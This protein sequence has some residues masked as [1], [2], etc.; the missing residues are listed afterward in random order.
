MDNRK[1]IEEDKLNALI[2]TWDC[3]TFH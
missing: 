3:N 2:Y 1:F